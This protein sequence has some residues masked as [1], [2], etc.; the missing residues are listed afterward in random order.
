MKFQKKDKLGLIFTTIFLLI[1]TLSIFIDIN[2]YIPNFSECLPLFIPFL[3]IIDIF[4]SIR[5]S[6]NK[7]ENEIR[8]KSNND[9]Y[10][11]IIPFIFGVIYCFFSII[12]FFITENEK[13]LSVLYFISG[14]IFIFKGL[15][16]IPSV[17][18]K[19]DNG[20]LYLENGKEINSFEIEHIESIVLSE[21][22]IRLN[23]HNNKKYIFSHLELNATEIEKTTIFIKKYFNIS[24]EHK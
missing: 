15:I 17:L 22:D 8:I 16:F 5:Y 1:I 12:F 24:I 3:Y 20:K 6:K 19:N 2:K 4:E 14:L 11:S 7:P 18:V 9:N 21:S 10:Y 13:L 23:L